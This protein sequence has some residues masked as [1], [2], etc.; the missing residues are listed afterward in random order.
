[1]KIIPIILTTVFITIIP[2]TITMIIIIITIT[3]AFLRRVDQPRPELRPRELQVAGQLQVP[4]G[5]LSAQ[6]VEVLRGHRGLVQQLQHLVPVIIAIYNSSSSSSN[7]YDV[8]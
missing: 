6:R 5:D 1:M 8:K 7:I 3:M 4:R 2:T